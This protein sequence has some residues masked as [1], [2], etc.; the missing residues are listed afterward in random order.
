MKEILRLPIVTS[1][2][3]GLLSGVLS[4]LIVAKVSQDWIIAPFPESIGDWNIER[5]GERHIVAS[6]D[7]EPLAYILHPG[8]KMKP[9][10]NDRWVM[11]DIALL[12][13]TLMIVCKENDID[14]QLFIREDGS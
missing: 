14:V 7:S 12:P 11:P 13:S 5:K 3:S 9:G 1:A 8:K 10:L 6:I 4:G 2:L